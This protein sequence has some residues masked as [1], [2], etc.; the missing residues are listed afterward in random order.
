MLV[1]KLDPKERLEKNPDS[2]GLDLIMKSNNNIDGSNII[3]HSF[4]CTCKY[5]TNIPK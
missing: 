4:L 2:W 1:S 5:V 3:F